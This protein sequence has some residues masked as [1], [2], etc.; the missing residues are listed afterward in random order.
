LKNYLIFYELGRFGGAP[1]GLPFPPLPP[2][3]AHRQPGHP[4]LAV[5]RL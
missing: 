4:P 2:T 5:Y 3:T 1:K